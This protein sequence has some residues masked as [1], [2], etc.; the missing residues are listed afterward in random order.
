VLKRDYFIAAVIDGV[1]CVRRA[2]DMQT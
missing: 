2:R 1:F